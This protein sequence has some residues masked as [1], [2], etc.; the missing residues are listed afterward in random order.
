MRGTRQSMT[1]RQS[2]FVVL[3]PL[4]PLEFSEVIFQLPIRRA[5][6]LAMNSA[7]GATREEIAPS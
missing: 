6:D 7:G 2:D 3:L 5:A 1:D 4:N